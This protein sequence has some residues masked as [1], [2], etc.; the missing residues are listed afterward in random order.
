MTWT[1]FPTGS[2][3][4]LLSL[5]PGEPYAPPLWVATAMEHLRTKRQDVH[6]VDL[7]RRLFNEAPEEARR[8]WDPGCPPAEME[9]L[10]ASGPL[11]D[12]LAR[13]VD[14][15][16]EAEV[17]VVGLSLP[18]RD[19]A[20]SCLLT[21]ALRQA[22]PDLVI[23]ARGVAMETASGQEAMTAAGA[24]YFIIGEGEVAFGAMLD[25]LLAGE[26]VPPTPGVIPSSR[27]PP[28]TFKAAG[29]T[30][31]EALP[32]PTFSDFDL[33]DYAPFS[34]GRYLPFVTSRG[35]VG[36]CAFCTDRPS[37]GPFRVYPPDELVAHLARL[38]RTHRLDRI[39]FRDLAINCRPD[40]L[41]AWCEG[42]AACKLDLVWVAEGTFLEGMTLEVLTAMR[43]AGCIALRL[44]L[45]SA[46][47][48][49]LEA[50]GKP[51]D[52]AT[53]GQVLTDARDAGL[54]VSVS[55]MVGFPGEKNRDLR[56]TAEFLKKHAACI[57]HVDLLAT[58]ELRSGCRLT[59]RPEEYGVQH[60]EGVF[61]TGYLDGAGAD[62]ALRH[63]RAQ[64]LLEVL[65]DLGIPVL[66]VLDDHARAGE[67]NPNL[68]RHRES[69]EQIS[70][71]RNA[72]QAGP[73][74]ARV[75]PMNREISLTVGGEAL[76]HPPGFTASVRLDGRK[77]DLSSGRWRTWRG[78]DQT[79][80]LEVALLFVPGR[81]VLHIA[82]P[83][84]HGLTFQLDLILEEPAHLEQVRVGLFPAPLLRRFLGPTGWGD[85]AL[86]DPPSRDLVLCPAP[87]DYL[88]V[89]EGEDAISEEGQVTAVAIHPTDGHAWQAVLRHEKGGAMVVLQQSASWE[90]GQEEG[91]PLEPGTHQLHA[92]RLD[93]VTSEAMERAARTGSL[94]PGE[95]EAPDF[96]LLHCPPGDLQLPPYL[97]PQLCGALRGVGY[98][99][100]VEDFNA[101]LHQ[102]L[103][104]E[105][106][107][108]LWGAAERDAWLDPDRFE[109][110]IWPPLGEVAWGRLCEVLDHL[111]RTLVILA[112]DAGVPVALK[113]AHLARSYR[114]GLRVV[115]CGPGI[116]WTSESAQ[117]TAPRRVL[118]PEHGTPLPHVQDVDV[119]LRGEVEQ[120]LPQLLRYLAEDGNLM[121]V[122]GA[123]LYRS[124]R[125]LDTGDPIP[126]EDLD[127][128]PLPDFSG[129]D[130]SLYSTR[131][132]PV[133]TSRGCPRNCVTCSRCTMGHPHRVR[134]PWRVVE[135]VE[136]QLGRAAP[137]ALEFTD[138]AING[139]LERLE[140]LCLGMVE[141][142]I[143]LPWRA[144]LMVR[145][146]M[147][148]E[149]LK[150][151][152]EAGCREL[153]L[154]VDSLCEHVLQ[155]MRKGFSL[156][157]L[158]ELLVRAR[159]AELRTS[160]SLMVG[161]PR[162]TPELFDDT[163][164]NLARLSPVI[165]RVEEVTICELA[166]GTRLWKDPAIFGI[167]TTAPRYWKS[168]QG[169]FGN[170]PEERQ[171]RK[172]ELLA[173]AASLNLLDE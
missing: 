114:D 110:E 93:R 105:L 21:R 148:G 64:D 58:C 155:A 158:E 118:H 106:R 38:A 69:L 30:P 34:H 134:N 44:G 41:L 152:K 6:P 52:E 26:E 9:A 116:Y 71:Q 142:G 77:L 74:Q 18:P 164:N 23:I 169:P 141:R 89:A 138:L 16:A 20:P 122:P 161:F 97:L 137:E 147:S 82:N 66:Q 2:T 55:L 11:A 140:T 40:Q 150:L 13:V 103:D 165:G 79:L 145:P 37:Q 168:W 61:H 135:E 56:R 65:T 70:S 111:P 133:E 43:R 104:P 157:Q 90:R 84:G 95:S 171:R 54:H 4:L 1:S 76:T 22:C 42:L 83:P 99:G 136:F 49:L 48:R 39:S 35:C 31:L 15:V 19:I 73:L 57:S 102:R 86:P 127:S 143:N 32:L 107:Q 17:K 94:D 78:E 115:I 92:G 27:R 72:V 91:G 154:G 167:D 10:F 132:V 80:H 28:F 29:P 14:A 8:A 85:L 46:S 117:G 146:E 51:F 149:L 101:Q 33:D 129:L 12:A 98:K 119:F 50:M 131:T 123:L 36:G 163:V 128:L 24:D 75:F 59:E 153:R 156:L 88:L 160:L 151:M 87:T 7:N 62:Q 67:P 3:T 63:Q 170:T 109:A 121:E 5:P 166:N 159:D 162:E 45:D 68:V 47:D 126:V 120:T 139:D 144:R 124:Q 96:C 60:G 81:L 113:L 100:S 172:E 108:R 130:L 173:R 112:E 25:P 53:A 125:W